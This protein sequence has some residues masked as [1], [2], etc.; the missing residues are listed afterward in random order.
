MDQPEFA[1]QLFDDK[2][3]S[4]D[5]IAMQKDDC[6]YQKDFINQLINLVRITPKQKIILRALV[7]NNNNMVA[8]AKQLNMTK[9]NVFIAKN[10]IMRVIRHEQNTN[11]KFQ[12]EIKELF[13]HESSQTN[14]P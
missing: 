8:V 4:P 14:N 1:E 2:I 9:Q 7:D 11:E 5:T 13:N 6:Q 10:R 3:P 12:K